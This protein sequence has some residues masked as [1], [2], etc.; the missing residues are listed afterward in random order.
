MEPLTSQHQPKK[1]EFTTNSIC[2]LLYSGWRKS[3][4][5]KSRS[6]YANPALVVAQQFWN[7]MQIFLLFLTIVIHY[8]VSSVA[9][10]RQTVDI[11]SHITKGSPGGLKTST[12]SAVF[13]CW[14]I[15]P[16]L[17]LPT[18]MYVVNADGCFLAMLVSILVFALLIWSRHDDDHQRNNPL[19]QYLP[20]SMTL[21]CI[22]QS[23]FVLWENV[24]SPTF[25]MWAVRGL[26]LVTICLLPFATY[27]SSPGGHCF[28]IL[29]V[30]WIAL[31][32]WSPKTLL[33]L[34]LED[35]KAISQA[36]DSSNLTPPHT[37][38]FEETLAFLCTLGSSVYNFAG[39]TY[40]WPH[41]KR[42]FS[43]IDRYMGWPSSGDL[44]WEENWK[45]WG[46]FAEQGVLPPFVPRGN[47]GSTTGA[48]LFWIVW[49][50]LPFLYCCYFA[51][52]I[53]LSLKIPSLLS[54]WVQQLACL[55]G[56]VHFLF[57]TDVVHYRYGRGHRN[58][59]SELFHL[60]EKWYGNFGNKVA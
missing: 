35:S 54:R 48:Q 9:A 37:V 45:I 17:L 23:E 1:G 22:P 14:R 38:C 12:N 11:V 7:G 50:V 6:M 25:H 21:Q 10:E 44:T 5:S 53:I 43:S 56:I 33:R 18:T 13:S 59:H 60:T 30:V 20:D 46:T 24:A 2:P 28:T 58:P 16:L 32:F 34:S 57:G 52:M 39:H 26:G 55:F 47:G 19:G 27:V 41:W 3:P 49:S 29:T 36:S 15:L 51:C 8:Q 4:Q 40:V 31:A 42:Q